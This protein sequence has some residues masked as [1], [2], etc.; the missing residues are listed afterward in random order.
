MKKILSIITTALLL[1]VIAVS[2]AQD[3]TVDTQLYGAQGSGTFMLN[4]KYY[5]TL[6]EAVN[7]RLGKGAKAAGANDDVIYLTRNAK[8]P[9]AKIDDPNISVIIDFAGWTYSFTDV[10]ATQ[11]STTGSFGLSIT[12]GADVTLKGLEQIDLHDTTANL[13]MVYVEGAD[14]K[15]TIED[16]PKMKVEPTQ[17]V[18]WAAN[19]AT[20]TVGSNSATA[21]TTISGKIA[22]TGGTSETSKPVVTFNNNTT[23]KASELKAD[24]AVVIVNSSEASTVDSFVAANNA[25]VVV[26]GSGDVKIESDDS[27]DTSSYEI[28]NTSSEATITVKEEGESSTTIPAGKAEKVVDGETQPQTDSSYVARIGSTMYESFNAAIAVANASASEL[29]VVL[30]K[31]ISIL[32]SINITNSMIIDGSGHGIITEGTATSGNMAAFDIINSGSSPIVVDVKDLFIEST[33][34]ARVFLINDGEEGVTYD[35]PN[36][37]NVTNLVITTDGEALY[38]NGPTEI[39]AYNCDFTHNGTYL[40]DKDPV[41]YS[42]IIVGYNGTINIYDSKIQSFGNGAATFPSGGTLNIYNTDISSLDDSV[43]GLTGY[44][45]WARHEKSYDTGANKDYCGSAIINVYSGSN[46]GKFRITDNGHTLANRISKINVLDGEYT[47]VSFSFVGDEASSASIAITG[48]TFDVDPSEYVAEGYVAKKTGVSE[49]T[50]VKATELEVTIGTE[51]KTMSLVEFAK[52]VNDGVE[53]YATATAKLLEDVDLT[54]VAW[55]PIGAASTPF[56]GV[57]DGANH[58]IKNLQISNST[59]QYQGLFG[60]V[61]YAEIKNLNLENCDVVGQKKSGILIGCVDDGYVEDGDQAITKGKG[62]FVLSNCTIDSTSSIKGNDNVGAFIGVAYVGTQFELSNLS[63]AATVTAEAASG[64][65]RAG[66]IAGSLQNFHFAIQNNGG[67]V[68]TY[69]VE[70]CNIS[71]TI[72]GLNSSGLFGGMNGSMELTRASVADTLTHSQLIIKDCTVSDDSARV[73]DAVYKLHESE[74]VVLNNF[75]VGDEQLT[76]L[77][78]K[79]ISKYSTSSFNEIKVLTGTSSKTYFCLMKHTGSGVPVSNPSY[80]TPIG[81]SKNN[82]EAVMNNHYHASNPP[83]TSYSTIT[84]SFEDVHAFFQDHPNGSVCPQERRFL[85]DVNHDP[86]NTYPENA[87]DTSN[88][89]GNGHI[90]ILSE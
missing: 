56:K 53:G 90:Y 10:T 86:F 19:G 27:S 4:G 69:K 14:T 46:T 85:Y 31:D 48:G 22:A 63:S 68:Y 74:F 87:T 83:Q 43:S 75:T 79:T 37:L 59:E 57:F 25:V 16:A 5:N 11:G 2:C 51:K 8:G 72:S 78:G 81:F 29:T 36:I 67:N 6:Q 1:L 7:A 47:D 3:V 61:R 45:F 24:A 13:T 70:N 9:G 32:D 77:A 42:A 21:P 89:N 39:N 38:S 88:R 18:F 50:V 52:K 82:Y 26:S 44:L 64:T 60:V 71:G 76:E 34:H 15:L 28:Q 12:G 30:L 66:G 55:T 80:S 41:Y 40:S 62:T 54:D 20:L 23:V 35:N 84:A 17:Y 58:T 65:A 33:K 49:W 73:A